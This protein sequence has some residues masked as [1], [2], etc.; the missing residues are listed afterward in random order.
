[1]HSRPV[2]ALHASVSQDW[3]I[4]LKGSKSQAYFC[5]VH[6]LEIAYSMFSVNLDEAFGMRRNSR[7]SKAYQILSVAP[8]LC[9]RLALPLVNL[10]RVMLHH[11]R[12]FGIVPNLAPLDVQN[13]QQSRSQ[14]AALINDLLSK[15]LL[16]RKSQF[17]HKISTLADL[18]E[19]LDSSFKRAAED[20]ASGDSLHPDRDWELLDSSH[21]DLNTCLRES[22]ILLKSFLH[23]LPE[24]QLTT[25]QSN[26]HEQS[27]CSS[28]SAGAC[29]HNLAH[30]RMAFL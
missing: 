23:V 19:E 17:V 13:F 30:R 21:Y 24:Q 27:V 16:T 9:E 15:I 7:C 20:L 14:R 18:I 1:M 2:L 4:P 8:A 26:L 11:V 3:R 12:H 29:S 28:S 22:V 6:K 25:F 5:C 10:L